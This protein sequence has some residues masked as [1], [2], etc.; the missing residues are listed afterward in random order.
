MRVSSNVLSMESA[1]SGRAREGLPVSC[2]RTFA[3]GLQASAALGEIQTAGGGPPRTAW[4]WMAN[5]SRNSLAGSMTRA[6]PRYRS[7]GIRLSHSLGVM[8]ILFLTVAFV[9]AP[10]SAEPTLAEEAAF[11]AA[12]ARVAGAVVRIEPLALTAV[13]SGP[14]AAPGSGA[15]TGTVVAPGFVLT[16]AFA[17]PS[18]VSDAVIVLRDGGRRAAKVKARDRSRGLVLLAVNG[19]P[20]TP[21][22]VPAP[23]RSLKPGQ[24][25]I[26]VGRGW[27]AGSPNV[28]VGIVSATNR[29]WGRGVQT[30]AAVSPVNYGGP[31]VDI[32]G[33]VIGILSPLPAEPAGMTE[34]TELYDAGI[35]FAVPLDDMLLALPRLMAGESL[36]AGF[37][38]VSYRSRDLINGE[39]VVASV[40]QGSPAARAGIVPGDRIM[41]IDGQKVARIADARHATGPKRAGDSVSLTIKR[42]DR[43]GKASRIDTTATLAA[44]M[45][46]WQRAVLGIVAAPDED[47]SEPGPVRI[48]WVLPGS[49]AERAELRIGDVIESI[50][51]GGAEATP[52]EGRGSA[53]GVLA[54]IE[55]GDRIAL[56]VRRDAAVKTVEVATTL[57]PGDVPPEGPPH[58]SPGGD[59]L[60]GPLDAVDVVRLEAADIADPAIAVMPRGK[61]PIGVL[62]WA[63]SPH[64]K[65][66]DA[67]AAPWKAAA[68]RHGI[69]IVLVG[70]SAPAAWGRTDIASVTRALA[71]LHARRPLDTSRIGIAGTEAGAP[72]AWM[73]AER[74]GSGAGGVALVGSALPRRADVAPAE[75]GTG[76]WI[77]LGPGE[78]DPGRQRITEDAQRLQKAGYPV[79][80]LSDIDSETP[81]ADLLCRWVSMLGLL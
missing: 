73:V 1:I 66:M 43:A 48:A 64:G 65:A 38:G 14:E 58:A 9:C 24:W 68:A 56:A 72:F 28:A 27:S 51:V 54:G 71:A 45:P 25:A 75:P 46:P 6:A 57:M 50:A 22:L 60:A 5:R 36:D 20:E 44:E 62:V 70:S 42:Q 37:L 21:A 2:R 30:D 52:V 40:R 55:P 7:M 26:A 23:R 31:L 34:G 11:Q 16:T 67:E 41:A 35:G 79:G 17:V 53:A 15:S 8:F 47:D 76:W 12:V 18:D 61:G 39:P 74:I 10:S 78:D 77:L 19:L 81:P 3:P 4:P 33:R 69:A 13:T 63:G 32:A 49:P 80:L 29:A 59:P